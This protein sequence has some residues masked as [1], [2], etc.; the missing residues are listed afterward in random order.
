[1]STLQRREL[2]QEMGAMPLAKT[3]AKG[4]LQLWRPRR[5]SRAVHQTRTSLGQADCCEWRQIL[6]GILVSQTDS[7]G[8]KK[9]NKLKVE[10][11]GEFL[12]FK[13]RAP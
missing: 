12:L 3:A 7:A 6:G 8:K 2:K 10:V 4:L 11:T 1:M 13:K 9:H 5:E